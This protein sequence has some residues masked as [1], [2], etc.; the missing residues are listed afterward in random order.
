LLLLLAG[1]GSSERS[2]R[3]GAPRALK[4][5]VEQPKQARVDRGIPLSIS[6]WTTGRGLM[7]T[8]GGVLLGTSDG[9]VTWVRI[10]SDAAPDHLDAV[11]RST[12]LGIR[13]TRLV[14]SRDG[15]RNWRDVGQLRF[16]RRGDDVGDADF[17][18][19]MHGWVAAGRKLLRTRDGGR[20]WERARQPCPDY[21]GGISFL[22]ARH[23]FF[24]CGS[25]P[26]TIDMAKT[27][28]A[29]NDGGDTWRLRER[30][31]VVAG[32]PCVH[33]DIP[34]QGGVVGIRFRTQRDG[35]LWTHRVGLYATHDGGHRWRLPLF[36]GDLVP[37][38]IAWPSRRRIFALLWQTGLIRSDDGGRHWQQL[39]PATPT[40]SVAVSP[41]SAT[42]AIGTGINGLFPDRGAILATTD[43][44]ATWRRRA[45][46][47]GIGVEQLVRVSPRE[48]W[49]LGSELRE[50]REAGP[51]RLF[52]SRDDGRTWSPRSLPRRAKIGFLS[53]PT[54]TTAYVTIDRRALYR[55]SDAGATWRLVRR[56]RDLGV[57][58]FAAASEGLWLRGQHDLLHT[59]DA[60][61]TWRPVGVAPRLRMF[62]IAVAD[63]RHWW[64]EGNV[65]APAAKSDEAPYKGRILRTADAG[66]AW[67]LIRLSAPMPGTSVFAFA[68]ARVGWAGDPWSGPYRTTDGGRTWRYVYPA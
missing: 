22:D 43:G 54:S 60:G 53:V 47:R 44:G 10:R 57:V 65:Y 55:S 32:R 66:H 58:A 29:T 26:A 59:S 39:F 9:G 27:L 41:S 33:G 12:A 31:C 49:A 11:G 61:K 52:R 50:R 23:G 64:I 17:V 2:L 35:L 15:G 14:A 21:F 38:S 20:T 51:L 3:V 16:A 25:V 68:N 63:A 24:L 18:D 56:A 67:D 1:C 5:S 48:V 37:Y 4:G 36:S 45:R 34:T 19:R 7:S 8:R 13:G 6:F 40:P 42:R 46:I 28:Y 62:A 30:S